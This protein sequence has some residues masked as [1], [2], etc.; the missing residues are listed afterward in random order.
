MKRATHQP[1]TISVKV[2]GGVYYKVWYVA[3]A[4]TII[5]QHS[6]RYDHLTALL[7]GSVLVSRDGGPAEE[8]HAPATIEIPAGCMHTFRTLAPHCAL[9]CIHNADRLDADGEPA[10]R[11][12]HHLE[13]E[14]D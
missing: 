8:Y 6:H 12:E 5:P 9:A 13:L 3:D 4:H 1:E 11:D 7:S 2:Y 14:E 10:V